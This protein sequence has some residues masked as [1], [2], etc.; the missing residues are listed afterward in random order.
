[1]NNA[2]LDPYNYIFGSY[3]P[4]Y[5]NKKDTNQLNYSGYTSV[6]QPKKETCND[7]KYSQKNCR[8]VDLHNFSNKSKFFN[9]NLQLSNYTDNRIYDVSENFI[10]RT[11]DKNSVGIH[12][13]YRAQPKTVEELRSKNDERKKPNK[14]LPLI[15]ETKKNIFHQY[16]GYQTQHVNKALKF[17]KHKS[18]DFFDTSRPYFQ[19][20]LKIIPNIEVKNDTLNNKHHSQVSGATHN[21]LKKQIQVEKFDD[22]TIY[23]NQIYNENSQK[24][25]DK[26][27]I[28]INKNEVFLQDTGLASYGIGDKVQSNIDLRNEEIFSDNMVLTGNKSNKTKSMMHLSAD[29]PFNKRDNNLKKTSMSYIKPHI[30][31]TDK[32][33]LYTKDGNI[34]LNIGETNKS[35]VHLRN[36][37]IQFTTGS[38]KDKNKSVKIIGKVNKKNNNTQIQVRDNTIHCKTNDMVISEST[39]EKNDNNFDEF[40]VLSGKHDYNQ[41][42]NFTKEKHSLATIDESHVFQG[43]ATKYID[44]VE[45]SETNRDNITQYN[46][47]VSEKKNQTIIP[48]GTINSQREQMNTVEK[49]ILNKDKVEKLYNTQSIDI[50]NTKDELETKIFNRNPNQECRKEYNK[51]IGTFTSKKKQLNSQREALPLLYKPLN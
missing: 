2:Q 30:K 48:E 37:S 18:N 3:Q 15:N 6:Y 25:V 24:I 27:T 39:T 13:Q 28:N 35:K 31:I 45:T 32:S 47:N 16:I 38:V 22:N 9:D 5:S 41:H 29:K 10:P 20:A 49:N 40:G 51:D 34:K 17:I 8:N 44:N 36:E 42:C 46:S 7:N 14:V 12:P 50:N 1:M 21:Q 23:H 33:T 26:S 19:K 43:N 4:L 11:I